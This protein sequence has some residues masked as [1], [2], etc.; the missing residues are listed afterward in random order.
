LKG[1][2]R[3]LDLLFRRYGP[4]FGRLSVKNDIHI[5]GCRLSYTLEFQEPEL[6]GKM[7][8]RPR[9]AA[10]LRGKSDNGSMRV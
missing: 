6:V 10:R 9:H 3:L 8:R 7:V 4:G 5:V 2:G 1:L